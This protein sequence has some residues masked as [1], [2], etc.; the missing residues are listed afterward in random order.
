MAWARIA[1]ATTDLPPGAENVRRQLIEAI[2][3]VLESRS[4]LD[5]IE[6][7]RRAGRR[8]WASTGLGVAVAPDEEGAKNA[9]RRGQPQT[10][11]AEAADI[12]LELAQ[13][14]ADEHGGALYRF[15]LLGE[16]QRGGSRQLGKLTVDLR[17]DADIETDKDVEAADLLRS[18]GLMVDNLVKHN[19]TLLGSTTG[20]VDKVVGLLDMATKQGD[21]LVQIKR[22]EFEHS[23][24]REDRMAEAEENERRDARLRDAME[25]LWPALEDLA[26]R[27]DPNMPNRKPKPPGGLAGEI[28]A[29][30]E[31]L[32]ENKRSELA[33][34][35][36]E[37]VWDL[38]QAAS[39]AT[40]DDETRAILQKIAE[41]WKG[42]DAK[43]GKALFEQVTKI[44]GPAHAMALLGLVK[45]AGL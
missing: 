24:K 28:A 40:S 2:A 25:R 4:K 13:G 45:R 43:T 11:P 29:I 35:L 7:S 23:D 14:H 10:D 33:N 26:R 38:L 8:G 6:I 20:M 5:S 17:D 41:A 9:G 22:M 21:A 27:W 42:T 44:L 19:S 18:A 3:N 30:L 12:L 37:T 32:D 31:D 15:L 34:A 36:G 1:N 39:K 16:S